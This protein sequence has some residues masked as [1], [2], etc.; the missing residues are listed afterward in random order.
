M[1]TGNVAVV[2]GS[3]VG[4]GRGLCLTLARHGAKVVALD[5]DGGNNAETARLVR[6]AGGECLPVTCDVGD[7]HQVGQA[8]ELV[9]GRFGRIDLLVNN[10]AVWDNSSLLEGTYD[11]QT[12]AFEL[13]V[14]ACALGSFNCASAAVPGLRAAGGGNI[15]NMITEHVKE[16]HYLTGRR[17]LGYDCAKFAQWR[18]TAILA[19]ELKA[20]HIRVNGLC[21]GATDTPMLRGEAPDLADRAMK[22]EDLGQAVLNVIAH[23][24]DGPTG[25]TYLFGTSGTP[26]EESVRAIAALAPAM[27]RRR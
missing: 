24:P 25:E 1:L 12:A 19:A 4:I 3:A 26:R 2:T 5:I 10:A 15:V 17:G 27:E 18:M 14:R 23:G 13:A 9:L 7:R 8:M 22:P 6:E 11:S 16:G 20:Y 21:F